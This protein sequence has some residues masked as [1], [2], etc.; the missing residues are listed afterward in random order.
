MSGMRG[1]GHL[2]ETINRIDCAHPGHADLLLNEEHGDVP[3][4]VAER[5]HLESGLS[6]VGLS[7]TPGNSEDRGNSGATT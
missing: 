1:I 6:A 7:A 4:D 2:Q 5:A 3:L